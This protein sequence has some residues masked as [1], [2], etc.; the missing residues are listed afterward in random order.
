MNK[1]KKIITI[2]IVVILIVAGGILGFSKY[3]ESKMQEMVDKGV[4]YLNQKEYEKAITTLDL[5]LDEKPND[6]KALKLKNMVDKYIEAKK[7]FDNGDVEKA[8]KL[9]DEIDKEDS[10]YKGFEEDVNNLRNQINTYMKK[11]K[12]MDENIN[13]VRN[14]INENKYNDAKN[15][16]DKLEKEKLS[17]IQKQQVSDLK[18]RVK[19]ELDKQKLEEKEKQEKQEKAVAENKKQNENSNNKICDT[20]ISALRSEE[21]GRAIKIAKAYASKIGMQN[22]SAQGVSE[23]PGVGKD[24]WTY[25]VTEPGEIML[26]VDDYGTVYKVS[27]GDTVAKKVS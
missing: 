18:G 7:S 6:D 4:G 5:A 15:I 22:V 10:N 9:I 1:N 27:A 8:N 23:I 25:I 16:I 26:Y 11:N 20:R 13:K 2:S 19:S 12:E 24:G 21:S 3:K 14:L 17:D